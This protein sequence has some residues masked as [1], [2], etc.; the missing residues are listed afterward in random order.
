MSASARARKPGF[1]PR[2]QSSLAVSADG[3]RWVLLNC[4]P[5]LREQIAHNPELWPDP[6]GPL[7]NSPDQGR[8]RHQRRRRP[9]HRPHQSARRHAFHD[10]WVDRVLRPSM[11]IRSSNVCNPQI[12]PRLELPLDHAINVEDHATTWPDRRSLRGTWKNRAVPRG[13]FRQEVLRQPRRRY[14][15]P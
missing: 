1:A 9:Y 6:N 15:R 11:P 12:V 3:T 13:Q 10:L 7:R 4:S 14:Y 5:D 2:T 8:H